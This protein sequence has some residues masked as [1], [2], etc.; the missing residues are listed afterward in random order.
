MKSFPLKNV[1]AIAWRK[2]RSFLKLPFSSK[3]LVPL[4]W[5]LL[6]LAR[7]IILLIP[8][9]YFSTWLGQSAKTVTYTPTLTSVQVQRAKR[10]GQVVRATANVTPWESVCFPQALVACWLL[11]LMGIPY[12]MHFGLAKNTDPDES[13]P[14]KAHAWV[15]A[16]PVAV[17]GGRNNLFKFTVVAS[18]TSPLLINVLA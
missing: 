5:L 15:T 9:R 2:V 16:G 12:I 14:M 11:R 18:Y 8:F 7:A 17:T 6:A 4:V 10:L 1:L 3:V 13:E